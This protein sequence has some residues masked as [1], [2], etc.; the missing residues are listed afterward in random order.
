MALQTNLLPA[1]PASRMD[2]GWGRGCLPPIH[3]PC[4]GLGKQQNLALCPCGKPGR[5]YWLL[6]SIWRS[7]GHCGRLRMN[8]QVQALSLP[9][10]VTPRFKSVILNKQK[11]HTVLLRKYRLLPTFWAKDNAV[12][13]SQSHPPLVC[14]TV[15]AFFLHR[16]DP[17]WY[18][19]HFIWEG[20]GGIPPWSGHFGVAVAEH[21][22]VAAHRAG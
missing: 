4:H 18:L 17:C 10:F 20:R 6:A 1:I 12:L 9:L 11:N 3:F 2:V 7:P 8:Q 13:A 16:D 22:F 5:S 19:F 14:R 21:S 15:Y